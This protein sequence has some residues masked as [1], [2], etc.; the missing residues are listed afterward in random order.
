MAFLSL[1]ML[2]A[3]WIFLLLP[4]PLIL[5]P[6][7]PTKRIF[8]YSSSSTI[9]CD[10][11]AGFSVA[12]RQRAQPGALSSVMVPIPDGKALQAFLQHHF[13]PIACQCVELLHVGIELGRA[14]CRERV[15]QYV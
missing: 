9:A 1:V 8:G 15:C 7:G 3:H 10:H 14:S 11:I 4:M 2:S 12:F 6:G 5:C 13:W